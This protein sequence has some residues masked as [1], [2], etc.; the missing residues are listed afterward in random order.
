MNDKELI[1]MMTAVM[2]ATRS[3][4][5]RPSDHGLIDTMRDAYRILRCVEE[6]ESNIASAL[7]GDLSIPK[8]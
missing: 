2:L 1:C 8:P 6:M 7:A 3:P 5:G 4:G